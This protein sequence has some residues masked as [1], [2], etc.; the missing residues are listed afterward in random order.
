[1]Y[2][3]RSK[4][5]LQSS[6]TELV[7]PQ[8]PI[9][10]ILTRSIVGFE[11]IGEPSIAQSLLLRNMKEMYSRPVYEDQHAGIW[12]YWIKRGGSLDDGMGHGA[13]TATELPD[14][15]EMYEQKGY[16]VISKVL[17][18]K[19]QGITALAYI[20]DQ[21]VTPEQ[22]RLLIEM[23]DNKEKLRHVWNVAVEGTGDEHNPPEFRK[24]RTFHLRMKHWDRD[25]VQLK[26]FDFGSHSQGHTPRSSRRSQR[27]KGSKEGTEDERKDRKGFPINKESVNREAA[28]RFMDED[29][30]ARLTM[31]AARFSVDPAATAALEE[32][33]PTETVGGETPSASP[34]DPSSSVQGSGEPPSSA[35]ESARDVEGEPPAGVAA[36]EDGGAG[37]SSQ[38]VAKQSPTAEKS[39]RSTHGGSERSS[40]VPRISGMP[41]Q[42]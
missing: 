39:R 37:K 30:V 22:I 8:F 10:V 11:M 28:L 2:H 29:E 4:D 33:G 9:D 36:A 26:A 3:E 40:S 7:S 21:A 18:D 12:L 19:P 41:P 15:E 23:K 13:A 6:S 1:V 16:W 42:R 25:N 27:P 31:A 34:R 38:R 5:L 17:G 24:S 32:G 20:E 14:P 35:R